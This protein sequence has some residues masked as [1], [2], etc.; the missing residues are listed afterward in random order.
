[1]PG[2]DEI[3]HVPA[4]EDRHELAGR[5]PVGAPDADGVEVL[6]RG[7]QIVELKIEHFLHAENVRPVGAD[8]LEN[9]LA[10]VRPVVLAVRGRPVANVE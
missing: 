9:E 6:E 7:Q 10:A 8:R 2:P 1:M 5:L 3:E 4:I